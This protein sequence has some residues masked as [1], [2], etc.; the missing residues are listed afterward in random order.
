[1]RSDERKPPFRFRLK[2]AEVRLRA[3]PAGIPTPSHVLVEL[4]AVE[5]LLFRFRHHRRQIHEVA[6]AAA[7]HR[8]VRRARYGAADERR[9]ATSTN[10][11]DRCDRCRHW[12]IETSWRA[13]SI[14][15]RSPLSSVVVAFHPRSVNARSTLA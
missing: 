10:A 4:L 12:R 14:M 1:M 7:I 9:I 2:A 15:T 11:A 3:F 8:R 6:G 13:Q 5:R